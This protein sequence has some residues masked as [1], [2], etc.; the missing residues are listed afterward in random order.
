MFD[1][2]GNVTWAGPGPVVEW[3]GRFALSGN[4]ED[5]EVEGIE[6]G[7]RFES[8]GQRKGEGYVYLS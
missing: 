6:Q 8:G 1:E 4:N 2:L 7:R 5:D 3:S